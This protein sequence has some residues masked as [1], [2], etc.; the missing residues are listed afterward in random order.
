MGVMGVPPGMGNQGYGTVP[1]AAAYKPPQR[2]APSPVDVEAQQAATYAAAFME[3]KVRAAFVRK[4]FIL[5]FI[6]LAFTIG[7]AA[8]FLFV[9]PVNEYIAG[10]KI[11]STSRDGTESCYRTAAEG[12]WVFYTS[13]ALTL[14][15]MIAIAYVFCK[16]C[17][18]NST[19][20]DKIMFIF[21]Q[22]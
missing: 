15:T 21:G 17:K 14:V 9:D 6:M 18:N 7:I 2:P 5:V 16:I 11:C 8:I 1:G 20:T 3:K 19:F 22:S 10:K 12:A 4:V 13:W